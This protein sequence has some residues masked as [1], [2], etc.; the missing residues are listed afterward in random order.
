MA[1]DKLYNLIVSSTNK[2]EILEEFNLW[3][4]FN[5]NIENIFK[6]NLDND[7]LYTILE[8]LYQNPNSQ[9]F[10]EFSSKILSSLIEQENN[11]CNYLR[12]NIHATNFGSNCLDPHYRIEVLLNN[13]DNHNNLSKLLDEIDLSQISYIKYNLEKFTSSKIK[14]DTL[15]AL[16]NILSENLVKL[17]P[18]LVKKTVEYIDKEILLLIEKNDL[19][20]GIKEEEVSNDY[21]TKFLAIK[22]Y[23]GEDIKNSSLIK[24]F[25]SNEIQDK[26]ILENFILQIDEKNLTPILDEDFQICVDIINNTPNLEERDK[27]NYI[28]IIIQKYQKEEYINVILKYYVNSTDEKIKQIIKNKSILKKSINIP[29]FKLSYEVIIYLLDNNYYNNHFI[30]NLNELINSSQ[31]LFSNEQKEIIKQKIQKFNLEENKKYSFIESLNIINNYFI[32]NIDLTLEETKEIIKTITKSLSEYME[33]ENLDIYFSDN[34]YN[35]YNGQYLSD[36]QF[37]VINIQKSMINKFLN[38]RLNLLERTRIFTTILHELRHHKQYCTKTPNSIYEYNMRKERYLL[39]YD[40]EYYSKN[41]DYVYEEIDA[42]KASYNMLQR[43][44]ELYFPYLLTLLQDE[45]IKDLN[46]EKELQ[47]TKNQEKDITLVYKNNVKFNDAFDILIK[48][49]KELLEQEPIFNLEYNQD[50]SIKSQEELLNSKTVENEDIIKGILK[51]RYK[52]NI[53]QTLIKNNTK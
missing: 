53:E 11:L 21:L 49:N 24:K 42:R 22:R 47:K 27:K 46:R 30:Y 25:L 14:R 50:G 1:T 4:E 35:N 19:F 16:I 51:N 15:S 13:L 40:K 52:Y 38:K 43:F 23:I 2:E 45:I 6:E 7:K 9:L 34:T 41:Y 8:F 20:H 33:L 10:K 31:H 17:E 48:Y 18:K 12:T 28:S 37:K 36:N 39:E 32:N 29:P 5:D 3:K 26:R 44:F